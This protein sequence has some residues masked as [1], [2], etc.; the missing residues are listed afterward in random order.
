MIHRTILSF[1]FFTA[2][3]SAQNIVINSEKPDAVI[4]YVNGKPITQAEF[5]QIALSV[6]PKVQEA[7]KGNP[8]EFLRYFG[9]MDKLVEQA[10]KEQ[11]EAKEPYKT[12]MRMMNLQ[13]LS[14]AM[15]QEQEYTDIVTGYDQEQ[16]YKKHADRYNEANAK[17]I[18]VSFSD[19]VTELKAKQRIT[20]LASRVKKGADFVALVKEFS[21]DEESKKKNGDF[22][23]HKTDQIPDTVKNAVFGLQKGQLTEPIK[24]PNGYY[25]FRLEE[26]V[27]KQYKD[28]KDDIYRELKLERKNL[29][30]TSVRNQVTVKAPDATATPVKPAQ[31]AK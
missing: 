4:A 3:L 17:L 13:I 30:L 18:Y 27:V 28:V 31:P 22:I 9:F 10:K 25:L 11:L 21:E 14:E 6:D 12:K 26:L 2:L 29:W 1:T 16:F 20:D 8:E 19:T 15:M 7:M 5:Q 24:L 23:I